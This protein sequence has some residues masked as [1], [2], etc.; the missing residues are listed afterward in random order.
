[1]GSLRSPAYV[2]RFLSLQPSLTSYRGW[3]RDAKKGNEDAK[4]RI[5]KHSICILEYS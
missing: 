5:E 3:S 4:I 1:V 2:T